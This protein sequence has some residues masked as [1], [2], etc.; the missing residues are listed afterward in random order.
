[1]NARAGPTKSLFTPKVIEED[2]EAEAEVLVAPEEDLDLEMIG[3]H[4]RMDLRQ[5]GILID[6]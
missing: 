1:M 3:T 6:Q 5:E 2:L 4:R